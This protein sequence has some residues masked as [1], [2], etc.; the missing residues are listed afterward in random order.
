MRSTVSESQRELSKWELLLLLLLLLLFV[1]VH[2]AC[3]SSIPRMCCGP[4]S[5]VTSGMS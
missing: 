5:L 4:Q 3:V 2:H 1:I